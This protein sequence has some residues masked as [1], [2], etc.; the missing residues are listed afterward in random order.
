MSKKLGERLIAAGLVSRDAVEQGL[1]QQRLTG[2]RLGDSLVEMGLLAEAT[3]LRFLASEFKTRYV[4]AEK[5]SRAQVPTELLDRV[6]VRTAEAHGLLPLA[7]DD[8]RRILSIVA[9]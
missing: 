8:E 2:H 5:L 6:P 7:V 4:S 3:L 9:A 1:E